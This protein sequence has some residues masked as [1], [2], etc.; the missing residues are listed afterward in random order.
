LFFNAKVSYV[1]DDDNEYDV[2]FEDGTVFTLKAR[3]VKKEVKPRK[4]T[5]SRSGSRGRS[6]ARK[7]ATPTPKPTKL[8][9]AE[10]AKPKPAEPAVDMTPTR[11]SARIAAAKAKAAESA[12][13]ED[14]GK[15]AASPS[16]GKAAPAAVGSKLCACLTGLNFAWLGALFFM[17]LFPLIL[18]SLHTLC[19]KDKCKPDIPVF[20]KNLEAYWDPQAFAAVF[21][22]AFALRLL[23][24]LPVGRVV[25]SVSGNEIRLNGFVTLLALLAAAPAL[26]YKKVDV[27]FVTDKYFHIMVSSLILAFVFSTVAAVIAK[28][29]GG[30]K[31]NVNAKGNTGN[32]IVD[33]FN[34]RELNPHFAR[35]DLKLQVGE[36]ISPLSCMFIDF[37][38]TRA[39]TQ[40]KHKSFL[41]WVFYKVLHFVDPTY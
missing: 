7:A 41:K 20:P 24:L 39:P 22:F 2:T 28:F 35:A 11:V 33:F 21:G 3:D 6:P 5:P 31:S 30:K 18:V 23:S 16:K 10:P 26:V 34:G 29:F 38:A 8:K 9:P 4:S 40:P 19:T 15:K 32:P 37:R 14:S 12:D 1:R 13:E 25:A 36:Q 17:A 27:G